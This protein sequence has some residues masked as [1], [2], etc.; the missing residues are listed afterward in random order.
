MHS[1]CDNIEF[2]IYDN[3]DEVA[4]EY[5]EW[6]LDWYEIDMIWYERSSGFIF[7]CFHLLYCKCHAT[8]EN[9]GGS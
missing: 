7:D 9:R 4:K 3:A 2:I 1:K 6:L 8:N 5:F